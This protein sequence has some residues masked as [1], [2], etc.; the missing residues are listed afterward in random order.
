MICAIIGQS[1]ASGVFGGWIHPQLDEYITSEERLKVIL[2]LI[3]G[4]LSRPGVPEEAGKT[5]SSCGVFWS[6]RSQRMLQ[7]HLIIWLV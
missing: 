4:V 7:A 1:Q 5:L 3:D 2:K 6:A